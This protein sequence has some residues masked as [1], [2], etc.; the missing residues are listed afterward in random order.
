MKESMNE[1]WMSKC[2][3]KWTDIRMGELL[4]EWIY[5]QIIW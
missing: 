2:M 5:K 4:N 1:K 3:S